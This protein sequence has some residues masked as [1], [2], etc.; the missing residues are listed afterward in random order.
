M[1]GG[2][3]GKRWRGARDGRARAAG[4]ERTNRLTD[5]DLELGAGDAGPPA[6]SAPLAEIRS[7]HISALRNEADH[8]LGVARKL[9]GSGAG[10]LSQEGLA[11]AVID[12]PV[13]SGGATRSLGSDA[14]GCPVS[15]VIAVNAGPVGTAVVGAH[16]PRREGGRSCAARDGE[17]TIRVDILV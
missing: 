4:D 9:L 11:D 8:G 3:S 2:E 13:H 17:A 5:W 7:V 15:L 12:G 1:T 6:R 14:L 10:D 16:M